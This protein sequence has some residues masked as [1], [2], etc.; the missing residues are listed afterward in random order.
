MSAF[1]PGPSDE[2]NIDREIRI[3]RMKRELEE[4]SGGSIV[5]GSFEEVSPELEEIFLER[6]CEFERAPWGI[7]IA[8]FGTESN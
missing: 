4:L 3:E 6:A 8:W 5:T 2:A 1:D 7:L